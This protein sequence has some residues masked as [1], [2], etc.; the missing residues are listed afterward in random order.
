MVQSKFRQRFGQLKVE[1]KDHFLRTLGTSRGLSEKVD[2]FIN[3]A[4]FRK[5]QRKRVLKSGAED[6]D[7][8]EHM[9][10]WARI[11]E[12]LYTRIKWL[13][14]FSSIN[15][16]ATYKIIK[17][18]TKNYFSIKDNTLEKQLKQYVQELPFRK[19]TQLATLTR[20]LIIFYSRAFTNDDI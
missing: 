1:Q 10:N 11:F 5:L 2:T 9:T 8:F 17:K 13:K 15:H 7:E 3:D 14:T 4:V 18:F 16:V 19:S 6:K 12:A 20:D